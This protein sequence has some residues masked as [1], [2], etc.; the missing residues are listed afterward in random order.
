[1]AYLYRHIRLDKNQP[2]YIGIGGLNSFDN[3]DRAHFKYQ[4]GEIWNRIANK[5]DYSIEIMLDNLSKEE[6]IVKEIEFI[7]LYGRMNLKTGFLANLTDGGE[8]SQNIVYDR[9]KN[10]IKVCAGDVFNRLT[11]VEETNSVKSTK[12]KLVR[13]FKCRC[14]CGNEHYARLSNLRNNS[15]KSCGCLQKETVRKI[16]KDAC[17]IHNT[18]PL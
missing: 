18:N 1:M 5:A 17:R 9:S 14:S 13:V 3:Y 12:G 6:A 2:F 15:I 10:K 11:I 16:K 4:R 8:G 7:K